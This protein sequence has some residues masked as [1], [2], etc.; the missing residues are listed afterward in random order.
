MNKIALITGASRGI[1]YALA[2]KMLAENYLVIGTSRRGTITGIDDENFCSIKLDLSDF[3]NFDSSVKYI[4]DKYGKI[5]I[6]INNAGIGPDL[7]S[8]NPKM[9][10]FD[11]T[12]NTNVKGIVFFTE[13]ML[14]LI[15]TNGIILNISSKM[16]SINICEL[17]DSVAYRMSKSALNM[18][19]KIL[20]NRLKD[21]IK[22]ASIHPGW[23]KTTI[24][25]DNMKHAPLTPKQSAENIFKCITRD[26]ENG[27]FWD[28]EN[29]VQLSW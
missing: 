7:G 23:V 11:L 4:S 3:N 18:Y 26:F 10:S 8:L 28:S 2:K 9:Q 19:T 21:V 5:D 20:S 17:S 13:K 15:N 16:C 1:G 14:K 25:E 29:N 24:V 22:V 6:L 27:T 12:F